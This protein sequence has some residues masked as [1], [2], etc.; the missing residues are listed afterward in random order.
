FNTF[1]GTVLEP[2]GSPLDDSV[3][4]RLPSPDL[5]TGTYLLSCK[6]PIDLAPPKFPVFPLVLG[7]GPQEGEKFAWFDLTNQAYRT[8][9]FS[10]GTWDNTEPILRIGTSAFFRIYASPTLRATLSGHELVVFWPASASDYTLEVSTNLSPGPDWT[11][12]TNGVATNATS[13]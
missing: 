7:R 1:A 12:V 9:T 3:P 8:T 13:F 5:P 4:L 6:A 2:D 11:P 10:A